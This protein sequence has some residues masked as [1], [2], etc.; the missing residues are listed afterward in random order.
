MLQP[1]MKF[2]GIAPGFVD[3]DVS[4]GDD[5]DELE[6]YES[7]IPGRIITSTTVNNFTLNEEMA[8]EPLS[9]LLVALLASKEQYSR[10]LHSHIQDSSVIRVDSAPRYPIVGPD[11]MNP[12]QMQYINYG[13]DELRQ[14]FHLPIIE[15]ARLLGICPTLFKKI[16]RKNNISRWPYRQIRSITKCIQSIEV[17]GNSASSA[18][19]KERYQQQISRLHHVLDQIMQDPDTTGESIELLK[20]IYSRIGEKITIYIL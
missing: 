7:N 8:N 20:S 14:H 6:R 1:S 3:D 18:D 5:E 10:S 12:K 9:R 19:E 2:P 15:V 4:E 11:P 13:L 17:A 16:C